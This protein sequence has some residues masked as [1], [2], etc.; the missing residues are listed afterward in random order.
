[1]K[2]LIFIFLF[3]LII[4]PSF[5]QP[6]DT[7]FYIGLN[8][9]PFFLTQLNF[10]IEKPI[11]HYLTF[12]SGFGYVIHGPGSFIKLGTDKELERSSGEYLSLGL[13]GHLKNKKISPIIGFRLINSLSFE[14]GYFV[15]LVSDTIFTMT[16][17]TSTGYNFGIGG[18]AGLSGRISKRFLFDLGFQLSFLVINGLCDFHSFAPGMGRNWDPQR[19]EFIT[20]IKYKL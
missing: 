5:G 1:M 9:A 7:S 15:S 20:Q 17:F 13:T 4:N 14:K 2:K 8:I 10:F 18:I 11:N 3:P 6:K 16:P 19:F 12:Y